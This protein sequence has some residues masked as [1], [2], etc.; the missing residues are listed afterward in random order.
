MKITS[1]AKSMLESVFTENDVNC[2]KAGLEESCCGSQV[3]LYA[4]KIDENED[5]VMVDGIAVVMD[6]AANQRMET[7]TLDVID[8]DLVFHDSAEQED[9]CSE[10]GCACGGG[11]C[12]DG[13]CDCDGDC[14]SD[15]S[16]CSDGD[17]G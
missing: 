7:I 12:S 16:S 3:V 17:C 15:G 13:D 11:G 5:H 4:G 1:E 8:G 14:S 2:L 9:C 10:G 6:E